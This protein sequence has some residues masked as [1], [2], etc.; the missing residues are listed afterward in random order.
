MNFIDAANQRVWSQPG[1]LHWLGSLSGFVDKG[2]LAAFR[3]IAD[4][5]RDQPILDIG[6]GAGR[7]IPI[8][9]G[10]SAQYVAI[11]YQPRMVARAR[12]LYPSANIQVGDGRDLSRFSDASFALVLFSY[13]GIDAVDRDGRARVLREVHRVL[14]EGGIFWFSTLNKEGRSPHDR[15]WR[16]YGSGEQG[17]TLT[18][19]LAQLRM[20]KQVPISVYNYARLRRLRC[21]G[22]GWLIAPFAAHEFGLVVHYT[23]LANQRKELEEAG[24]RSQ[25]EVFAPNGAVISESDNLNTIDFF[26]IISRK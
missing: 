17:S 23:T 11:D 1:V 24:F 6:V 26:N 7:T 16:L 2:E 21:E 5:V 22:D 14:R 9:S 3:H 19:M 4:E 18:R 20:L 12:A 25:L 8:L 13:A 10:L 15:P